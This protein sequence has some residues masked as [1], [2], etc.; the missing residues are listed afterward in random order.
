MNKFSKLIHSVKLRLFLL[1]V[2][3]VAIAFVCQYFGYLWAYFAISIFSAL[4]SI[5]VL[6]GRRERDCYKVIVFLCILMMPLLGFGYANATKETKG[7]KRI[8]KEWS[9][10]IYRNRKSVF[11]SSET[12]ET[13]KKANTEAHKNCSYIVDTIGMPC[14][15][16]AN[17]KYYSFG[18]AY[19]KDMFEECQK[20]TK[21]I[22]VQCHKIMPGKLWT[23]LFDILRTKA[24]DGVDV[25]LIYDDAECTNYISKDDFN[26]M[27]NHGIDTVAFNEVKG[28]KAFINSKNYKRLTV[29]DGKV[30]F[31]GG[32]NIDDE[33]VTNIENV[34]ATKDCGLKIVGNAVKNLIIMFFEDYQFAM[35]KVVNLQD[36]LADSNTTATKDWVLPYST[37]PVSMDH[38]NKNI[39]LSMIHNAKESISITTSYLSLDDEFKNALIVTAKSGVK[40]RLVFSSEKVKKSVRT[41]ARSY[42]YELMKEGIEVYEYKGCKMTTR[43]ILIDNNSALISTSNIDCLNTYKHFNA[44]TYVYGTSVILMINDM[45]DIINQSQLVTIKDLQKRRFSEKVS[46]LWSKFIALFR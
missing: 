45:R 17:I 9:D 12:M 36:Y 46:S 43:L 2:L 25:K 37:N 32:F 18:E 21:Y 22:L 33:Y 27:Q 28:N 23:E 16:D 3:N 29:I 44:G 42:F 4:V 34:S 14:F 40:V 39:L 20:A 15:Q 8:K 24:R 6:A 10:I 38:T 7:N 5:F 26:K 19:F 1:F 31:F 13:L 30:G 41:L 11:Q 35:K